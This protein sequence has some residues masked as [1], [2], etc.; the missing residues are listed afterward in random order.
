MGGGVMAGNRGIAA[1][2]DQLAVFDDHR[3]YRHFACCRGLAGL[4]QRQAHPVFVAQALIAHT[5]PNFFI[6]AARACSC[7]WPM[8]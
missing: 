5:S 8:A 4:R 2:G 3:P 6:H 7:A 1:S